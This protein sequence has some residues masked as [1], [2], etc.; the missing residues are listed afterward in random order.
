MKG[1]KLCCRLLIAIL[2]LTTSM[3]FSGETE[4]LYYAIVQDGVTCGYAHVIVSDTVVDGQ[5]AIYLDDNLR[6]KIS[7]LGASV[8]GKYRFEYL[9]DPQT[10][11]YFFH[12]SDIDQG[13]MKIGGE[14]AVVGD[15]VHIQSYPGDEATTVFL[16]EGT[17]LQ[18][19][20]FYPHLVRDFVE[21]S[22]NESEHQVFIEAD[23]AVHDVSYTRIGDEI[24]ELIGQEYDALVVKT[25]DK[26]TG[27]HTQIWIDKVTGLLIKGDFTVRNLYL[28]DA[29]IV[30]R[31]EEADL[32]EKILIDAGVSISDPRAISYM[33][34]RGRMQPGGAWITE[35]SL[36][37]PGQKFEGTVKD[38]LIDGVFEIS[39]SRYDGTGAPP[40]PNDFSADESLRE[41]L[42]PGDMIESDEPVLIKKATELTAGASDAW[43]AAIRLSQWVNEEIIG[44][45]PGGGTAINTY[46]TRLGECGSHSNLLAAFCRAVNIPCRVVFGCMYAPN[47][48]GVFG[49][50]AWNEIYMG[51]AGWIPVDATVE[52]VDY[53]D[54]GHIRLGERKSKAIMF[55]PIEMEVIDY[56]VGEGAFADLA[57]SSEDAVYDDYIGRYQGSQEILTVLVQGGGLALDIPSKMIFEL[58]DADKEGEWYFK[59]TSAASV[60]FEKDDL[61]QVVKLIINSRQRMPKKADEAI[62]VSDTDIPDTY[63]PYIGTYTIPMQNRELSITCQDKELAIILPG[64]RTITLTEQKDKG[65]W[66]AELSEHDRLSVAFSSDDNGLVE[67]MIL[68][69]LAVCTRMESGGGN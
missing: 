68:G 1:Y 15:T 38:N 39:H 63:R 22:L 32:D 43:D 12:T 40:F 51:D 3:A 61:G 7:A 56:S 67:A 8:E 11:Q 49:Q 64:D 50:H 55:N 29:G 27:I 65:T 47:D 36:N 30:D 42:K 31:I 37:L 57:G 9:V 54:C 16:P 45:I 4:N 26:F 25:L 10:G 19:M 62:T 35:E 13:S 21:N 14:M 33:K 48:G 53:V 59:I 20:R 28:T 18:T 34:I 2:M 23:G 52:E 41:Y 46:N 44:A 58:K 60:S 6:L 5:P 17:I 24:V 69:Q 66:V